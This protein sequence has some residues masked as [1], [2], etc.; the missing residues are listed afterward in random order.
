MGW[1]Q[2][3]IQAFIKSDSSNFLKKTLKKIHKENK[4]LLLASKA[5]SAQWDKQREMFWKKDLIWNQWL[6]SIHFLS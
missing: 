4:F 6:F 1:M 2:M 3:I 5:I